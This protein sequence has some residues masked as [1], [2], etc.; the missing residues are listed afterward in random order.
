MAERSKLRFDAGG[1]LEPG[2]YLFAPDEIIEQFG[3]ASARREQLGRVFKEIVARLRTAAVVRRCWVS[4]SFAS[5]KLAPGDIDL[6]LLV[7]D[8]SDTVTT[9]WQF[10]DIFEHERAKLTYGA[11]IFWMTESGAAAMLDK[12]LDCLQT[13]R[14]GRTRGILE[15]KL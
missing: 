11:D 9:S 7:S 14:D 1:E 2:I 4:G 5:L 15:I 12:V 6:W 13:T 3:R 10:T 8:A